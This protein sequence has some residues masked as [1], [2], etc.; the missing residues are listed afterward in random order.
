M[1]TIY[2]RKNGVWY[3]N[4]VNHRGQ[5]RQESLRT[6]RERT[7]RKLRERYERER[8][9]H[10]CGES[11]A[12]SVRGAVEE[13]LA[14]HAGRV[15]PGTL[16]F[17]R[18]KFSNFVSWLGSAASAPLASV[19]RQTVIRYRRERL[20]T[21]SRSTVRGDVAALGLLFAWAVDEAGYLSYT[22]ITQMLRR[23]DNNGTREPN[24]GKD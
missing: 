12:V 14:L 24:H 7:A 21:S 22:P 13:F 2:R 5:R 1:S 4:Y 17:Y 15:A 20:A 6:K 10:L 11:S 3:I 8:E 19:D 9:R 18:A 23:T 16:G